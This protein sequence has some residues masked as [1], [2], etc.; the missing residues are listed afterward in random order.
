MYAFAYAF[1]VFCLGSHS[2]E[3]D[4]KAA[5]PLGRGVGRSRTAASRI[6]N[7]LP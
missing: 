7:P 4:D 2:Q 3:A 5:R 1:E 6:C